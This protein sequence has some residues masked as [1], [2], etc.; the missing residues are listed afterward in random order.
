MPVEVKERP[1]EG[2]RLH[3]VQPRPMAEGDRWRASWISNFATKRR[4]CGVPARAWALLLQNAWQKRA[5]RQFSWRAIII[6]SSKRYRGSQRKGARLQR[7]LRISE[8]GR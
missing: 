8:I 6:G 2:R 1:G 7:L 5:L 3:L 4:W